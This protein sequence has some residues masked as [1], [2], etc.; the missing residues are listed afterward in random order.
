MLA[1]EPRGNTRGNLCQAKGVVLFTLTWVA[2]R[3]SQ[4]N[5]C[6]TRG[7][8]KVQ[9]K[10]VVL[11]TLTKVDMCGPKKVLPRGTEAYYRLPKVSSNHSVAV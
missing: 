4:C 2:I 10:V 5:L 8:P 11:F 6:V 7:A 3:V 1:K 9:H